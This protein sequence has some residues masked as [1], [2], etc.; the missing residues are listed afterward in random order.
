MFMFGLPFLARRL[1]GVVVAPSTDPPGGYRSQ[2]RL[3]RPVL[4]A[5]ESLDPLEPLNPL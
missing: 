3:P 4:D 2:V 5:L 1:D